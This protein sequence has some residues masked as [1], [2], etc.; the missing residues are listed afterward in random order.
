MQRYNFFVLNHDFN[1]IFRIN[2]IFKLA[3]LNLG[4]FENFGSDGKQKEYITI[5]LLLSFPSIY[6]L[7]SQL[8]C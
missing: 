1:K 2:T 6:L 8:D 7:C 5:L 4:V 3:K